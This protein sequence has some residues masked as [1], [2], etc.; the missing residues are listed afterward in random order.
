MRL[1]CLA[2]TAAILALST[3]AVR[4]QDAA[5]TNQGQTAASA[6]QTQ[7][8]IDRAAAAN[9]YVFLL[10]WKEDSL[11]TGKAWAMLKPAVAKMADVA[12]FISIRITNPAEKTIVDKYGASRAPMPLVLA[13]A[14]SGAVTRAFTK[15]FDEKEL[16]TAFVSPCMER[17]L[18]ALQSRKLVFLCFVDQVDPQ[19]KIAIP[20]GVENFK[21]DKKYG[22]ATEIVVVNVRDA[23]EATFLKELEVRKGAAPLTI[24][25][26]PP[27]A[28]IGRFGSET[29]KE[30]LVAKLTAA[31]SSCCPGG[32]CGSGGCGPKK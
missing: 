1:C 29:S 24:F 32:K 8:A 4:A 11:Q 21:A 20:K 6:S 31:Q 28:M 7:D 14:P 3:G 22:A 15:T 25:L 30:T 26:A 17:S 2:I 5:A 19:A 13:I 27:G 23:N 10:F 16:R 18:K 12:V 9:K